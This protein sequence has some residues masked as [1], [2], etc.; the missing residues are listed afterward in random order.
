MY[1]VCGLQFAHEAAES[2]Q[3]SIETSSQLGFRSL[4]RASVPCPSA[5][6]GQLLLQCRRVKGPR[7]GEYGT[8]ANAGQH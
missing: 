3:E 8:G 1:P 4:F 2:A 5:H 7:V 6:T